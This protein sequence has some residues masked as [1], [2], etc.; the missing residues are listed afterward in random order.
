MEKTDPA[1]T[2]KPSGLPPKPSHKLLDAKRIAPSD[3]SRPEAR[4]DTLKNE[5]SA[6]VLDVLT[7]EFKNALKQSVKGLIDAGNVLIRAKSQLK[8]GQWED[9]VIRTLRFGE[10]K[11]NGAANLRKAQELMLLARHEVISNPSHW[12]ALPPR[13]RT[14]TELLQIPTENLLEH[15]ASGIIHSGMTRSDAVKLKPHAPNG[16][17]NSRNPA[18]VAPAL[19][20]AIKV[21]LHF[22]INVGRP[23]VVIAYIRSLKREPGLPS[24][25]DFDRAVQFVEQI[26]QSKEGR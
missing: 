12:H 8:H 1:D 5:I 23:D 25:E 4:K 11:R 17:G 15:I 14:L 22:C 21:L 10:R 9:W 6:S 20:D 18:P 26:Y 2:I 16:N 3:K 13:I 24:R 19:Q 7:A